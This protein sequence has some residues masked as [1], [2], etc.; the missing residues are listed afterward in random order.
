M[1][2]FITT[3]PV[4]GI[5]AVPTKTAGARCIRQPIPFLRGNGKITPSFRLTRRIKSLFPRP[6]NCVKSA[7][8]VSSSPLFCPPKGS[9]R[10]FWLWL[11]C[12]WRRLPSVFW[13]LA[14]GQDAN[15]DLRNYHFYNAYAFLNN[16]YAQDLLPSQTPYFYNPLMDVPFFVLATHAPAKV[17]GF[18]LGI[19]AG[20]EFY[21]SFL[22]RA[23]RADCAAPEQSKSQFAPL[24]RHSA[25][26]AAEVSRR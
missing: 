2:S 8:S 23:R 6:H 26:W 24:W 20:T 9:L 3:A 7:M 11:F 14:L 15:W 19:C 17:A 21:P 25:C 22:D 12:F 18:C 5:T 16:R 4:Y 13:R 10:G 1:A